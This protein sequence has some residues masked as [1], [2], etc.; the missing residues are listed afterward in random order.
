[1]GF[2]GIGRDFQ[3]LCI[4]LHMPHVSCYAQVQSD[5]R[6]IGSLCAYKSVKKQQQDACH[7]QKPQ[8]YQSLLNH[9]NLSGIRLGSLFFGSS[10]KYPALPYSACP[11]T[12]M[13]RYSVDI[14]NHYQLKEYP[15]QTDGPTQG[16]QLCL[17][18][19]KSNSGIEYQQ[20]T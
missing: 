13:L 9:Q 16:L 15:F 8:S 7:P 1:M 10:C 12:T 19:S 6:L 11:T 4:I 3:E 20:T 2:C 17:C 14:Q 5:F 18:L